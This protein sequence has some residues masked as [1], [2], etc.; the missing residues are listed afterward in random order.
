MHLSHVA[1][2]LAGVAALSACEQQPAREAGSE[3][4]QPVAPPDQPA[5][6]AS[7]A[8]A[9]AAAPAPAV[10]RED[11]TAGENDGVPDI[12]PAPLSAEAARTEAGA[13]ANLLSWARGIELREFDQAWDLMG[14]AAK[15]KLSKQQFNALF[16]QLQDLT[17]VVPGGRME[18]AAGSSYYTVPATI[19]GTRADGRGATL[20]GEVILRRVND[21]DGATPEQL[22][23]HI[24][25]VEL[26]PG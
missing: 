16:Q 5:L 6:A 21:I 19:T 20:R 10:D 2:L 9:T 22:A 25:S 26:S 8:S 14:D 7:P 1:A 3:V 4:D 11:A 23:W 15:A 13:R 12:T 24:V 17:V 18:G